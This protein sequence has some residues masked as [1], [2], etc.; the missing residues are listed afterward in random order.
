MKCH[1][2]FFA[3]ILLFIFTQ[4]SNSQSLADKIDNLMNDYV[5]NQQFMGT[6][7]VADRGEI[8]FVKGYG[9]ANVDLNTPNTPD[10]KFMIGSITKQFTAM[11]VTQ[12]IEK[13]K[14][15]LDN[16]ISDLLPIFPKDIGDKITVEMLLTHT[17]GLP[18][19][20]GIEK[21]YY[22]STHDEYLREFLK[23]V[24]EEGMRFEPGEGYGYSN[25]GYHILGLIIEKVTGKTYE[26]VLN[27][28]I[29]KPLGMSDT[30]CKR[31]DL[32]LENEAY[33]YQKLPGRY[34]TWNKSLSFDPYILGFGAGFLYS[35]VGDL[36]KFS[37]ALSTN[38]L[39]SKEYMEMYLKMRNVKSRPPIPHIPEKL[40]KDFFGTC[41]NGFVGEISI[42]EDPD[43][44]NKQTFYWHD[45]TWNLFKSNHFHYSGNEQVII[46]CSNGSFLCE[47]NEIVLK[48]HQILNNRPYQD[49]RIRHS[50]SQ[51]ISEDIA[52]HAGIPAVISEYLRFKNDTLNFIIPG[53]AYF[54]NASRVVAGMQQFGPEDAILILKTVTSEFPESWQAYDALGETYLMKA[55]TILAIQSYRKSLELNP[56]N[57]NAAETLKVLEN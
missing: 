8:V 39:L 18:F 14:L 56:Q 10:T 41:G 19:P 35:T 31:K 9:L 51:Y 11:L 57:K 5:A 36:F 3:I 21:Y 32:V 23:Q 37:M 25:A 4:R 30:G 54:I 44:K 42:I 1:R 20:E 50:L 53:E 49:I 13:G 28:Q 48:L 12:L 27:E 15:R 29:L 34:I 45:G 6:V 40:V 46:I 22:V 16:T 43:S 33:S 7:L 26:E 52:M 17:S 24:S 38:K 47:G 55:D 2:L